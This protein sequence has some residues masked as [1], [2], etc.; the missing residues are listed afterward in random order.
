M[1][2]TN[3]EKL[4]ESMPKGIKKRS[5]FLNVLGKGLQENELVII[6]R[7]CALANLRNYID[8][9]PYIPIPEE[10]ADIYKCNN[11]ADRINMLQESLK[12]MLSTLDEENE[13]IET[14]YENLIHLIDDL[15][16]KLLEKGQQKLK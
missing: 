15:L 11:T 13:G 7:T 3:M 1:K 5:L 12:N 9:K 8:R 4:P 10:L 6:E 16:V 2:N 14:A